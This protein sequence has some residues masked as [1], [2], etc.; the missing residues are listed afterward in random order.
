MLLKLAMSTFHSELKSWKWFVALSPETAKL[1]TFIIRAP[2]NF[3]KIWSPKVGGKKFPVCSEVSILLQ[4]VSGT[5]WAHTWLVKHRNCI[6]SYGIFRKLGEPHS[7][8]KN[9]NLQQETS[10]SSATDCTGRSP[11]SSILRKCKISICTWAPSPE[12]GTSRLAQLCRRQVPLPPKPLQWQPT[13]S[14]P[15]P[16]FRSILSMHF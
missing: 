5:Q 10:L 13:S 8:E 4:Y 3:M 14:A 2:I 16:R 15:L 1:C 9:Y 7:W 6:V 12:R 11:F